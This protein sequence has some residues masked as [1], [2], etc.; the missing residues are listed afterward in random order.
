MHTFK[1]EHDAF[2][3]H[4]SDRYSHSVTISFILHYPTFYHFL[5]TLSAIL[6]LCFW[7]LIL[8]WRQLFAFAS[9]LCAPQEAHK[10]WWEAAK[11]T[12]ESQWRIVSN[13]FIFRLPTILLVHSD[14]FNLKRHYRLCKQSIGTNNYWTWHDLNV[15]TNNKYS[16]LSVISLCQSVLQFGSYL[17]LFFFYKSLLL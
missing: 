4:R 9:S 12:D 3:V 16:C 17:R 8:R 10:C 2:L 6:R 15:L 7:S 14:Y 5:C 11:F 1:D 13:S